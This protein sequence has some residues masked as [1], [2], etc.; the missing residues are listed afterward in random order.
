MPVNYKNLTLIDLPNG[1]KFPVQTYFQQ[2]RRKTEDMAL[3]LPHVL[4]LIE[5][6]R[7]HE[8]GNINSDRTLK[9]EICCEWEAISRRAKV[10]WALEHGH[11]VLSLQHDGVVL[12]IRADCSVEEVRKNLQR[13]SSI[14]TAYE[15]PVSNKPME[16]PGIED[17]RPSLSAAGRPIHVMK[18]R[19]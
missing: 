10:R 19:I 16:T 4:E 8:G 2:Q 1:L 6:W 18:Y 12:A 5:Y 13:A 3:R 9:S 15:I 17:Y 14:A 7:K 11:D